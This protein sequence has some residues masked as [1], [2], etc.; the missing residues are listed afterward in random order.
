MEKNAAKNLLTR[1]RV[2]LFRCFSPTSMYQL[3]S[4]L[5][6]VKL[7]T[8]RS[9]KATPSLRF[10]CSALVY[11]P[12]SA[13]KIIISPLRQWQPDTQEGAMT[14]DALLSHEA[15]DFSPQPYSFPTERNVAH[16]PSAPLSVTLPNLLGQISPDIEEM[17]FLPPL[18]PCAQRATL[19]IHR[20]SFSNIDSSTRP[21]TTRV[22]KM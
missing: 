2:R 7:Q 4:L 6:N 9:S 5:Y 12:L 11:C 8:K 13:R 20:P 15:S 16:F 14:V 10:A 19:R 21:K 18:P 17:F 3:V 22:V 1:R